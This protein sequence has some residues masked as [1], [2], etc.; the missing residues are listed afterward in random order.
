MSTV[1]AEFKQ[2]A[3]RRGD[4]AFLYVESVTAE[5]YGIEAGPRT[6]REVAREVERL[7][8]AYAAAGYSHGH[9]VGLLLENRP[10]FFT[11]WLALNGLGISIVPINADLRSAELGYLIAHSGITLAVVQPGSE[12][13]LRAAAGEANVQLETIRP[14]VSGQIPAARS[15]ARTPSR[16]IGRDTECALLYTS[17]TTGR[18][19]G[20]QLAN[21]YFLRAGEWYLGLGGLAAVQP[22]VERFV[23][24][25]PLSHM[26]AL[27][28]S[29][30]AAILSGG[31]IVQL[32]RFHPKT[33]WQS[34]RESGATVAHYLGVMPAMLLAAPAGESDRLHDLRFGFG[35]GVEP[36]HHAAFEARFGLPLLEAWAMTETGAAACIMAHREPRHVG[37]RCFGRAE[38]FVETRIV[39]KKGADVGADVAGELLVRAAGEDGRADFFLGYLKDEPAT[40]VAWADGWF[41]TGDV[42][43][44]SAAG[45]FHFVDRRKNLIRRSGENISAVEVESVLNEHPAVAASAVA[46]TPDPT[47]GDEVLACIVLRKADN[48]P[49]PE[50]I[51]A[52]VVRHVLAR[53]AYFKAPGYVA[54][55]DALPLTASQK[56]QRTELR[57]LAKRLPGTPECFDMRMLKRRQKR[58]DAAATGQ[59][60]LTGQGGPTG[61]GGLSGAGSLSGAG[62]LTDPGTMGAGTGTAAPADAGMLDGIADLGLPRKPGTPAPVAPRRDDDDGA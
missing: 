49:P 57:E 44:R 17:G 18:P 21:G 9:R 48:L 23:T 43:R 59:G 19:K 58:I 62:F 52:S 36:R 20:C 32:D 10:A 7:R 16:P 41:H 25:L 47:R 2:V 39:D 45:D 14:E 27:A 3:A 29:S 40:E 60:A 53:L 13:G 28:F 12:G 56:V 35:A 61:Q 24:P 1:Y 54:F 4:A 33:W 30:M 5:T 42:V 8:K 31:T 34:V 50:K 6:W 55:V 51:A 15:L 26:N 37:T 11:H 46:P 38:P 22:D